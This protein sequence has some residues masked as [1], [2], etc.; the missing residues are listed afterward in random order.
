MSKKAGA[1][2]DIERCYEAW[3]EALQ[4]QQPGSLRVRMNHKNAAIFKNLLKRFSVE[5]L[6]TVVRF[7]VWNWSTIQKTVVPWYTRD[8]V[9][10]DPPAIAYLADQL[11]VLVGKA[12]ESPVMPAL[13]EVSGDKAERL[14]PNTLVDYVQTFLWGLHERLPC[15]SGAPVV[16]KDEDV[17]TGEVTGSFCS[18]DGCMAR[19][20]SLALSQSETAEDDQD[21]EILLD[22]I[23]RIASN[24]DA[25]RMK[26]LPL[27][28][29]TPCE[30]ERRHE[31]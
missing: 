30:E 15:L 25:A 2:P 22:M 5:D 31:V 24:G 6:I 27:P 4:E 1:K 12:A 20:L 13:P 16:L 8:R 7:A 9:I 11:A 17:V 23:Y 18:C 26:P 10:P 14:F 3:Q 19:W 29:Y 28:R 21:Q